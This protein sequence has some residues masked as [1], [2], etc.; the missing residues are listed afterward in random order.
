MTELLL[1]QLDL[2]HL[3]SA[4]EPIEDACRVETLSKIILGSD[5]LIRLTVTFKAD[6]SDCFYCQLSQ[7]A[8]AQGF[9]LV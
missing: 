3:S 8:T 6:Q 7:M 1:N 5:W 4:K 9:P 2:F